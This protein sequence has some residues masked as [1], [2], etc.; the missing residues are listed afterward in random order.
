MPSFTVYTLGAS[1]I[2]ISG[3]AV[4]SGFSQGD[5]SH[6][7]G[8]TIT[9]NSNAWEQVSVF[10]DDANFNDSENGQTL[11][12][13]TTYDTLTG[14]T[15]SERVEAEYTLTVQDPDGNTYTI[16]G[17]NINEPGVTSFATVEG[18]AFIG[19]V[20]EFPPQGVPLTVIATSEGPGGGTTPY[21]AYA[22][23]PC[24]T[25]GTRIETPSGKRLIEDI[26]VGDYVYTLDSGAR[27]VL[28]TGR[29]H[30]SA[31]DLRDQPRLRPIL[32]Q[33]GAFG[34]QEPVRDMLVSPQHR[35]LLRDP[36]VQMMFGCEEVLVPA[37]HL[38]NGHSVVQVDSDEGV[39]YLHI[40]F[41]GHEIVM[42]DGLPTES[43][44]PGA[45]VMS[46]F[47]AQVCAELEA[48][49]PGCSL[50]KG[51]VAARLCLTGHDARAL[52]P[53]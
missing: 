15:G 45:T 21:S 17:F 52:T 8:E 37:I 16:I 30:L 20:G 11:D 13:A 2:S 10:D 3:G 14:L 49:F 44:F 22:T 36:M 7:M 50:D 35:V 31:R 43:F 33:K 6:L 47:D 39:D 5:G 53:A 18:L 23:P 51:A 40:A 4:L 26:E 9:L 19:D 32:I 48:L 46:G 41:D 12:G 38:V 24:F 34:G 28:W 42:S 1:Q 27:P 25:P 29:T